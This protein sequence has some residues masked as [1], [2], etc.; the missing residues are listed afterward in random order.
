VCTGALQSIP[1]DVNEAATVDGASPWQTFRL[2][3]L[4]LLLVSVAPLLIASFAF[5]FNNF[6]VI[7]MLTNGGPRD[8]DAPIPVGFTDILI[9]MVYKVAFT[10]QNRDYGLASA[11]S[12]II[13]LI[14]AIIAVVS[15][16]RTK[17]LEEIQR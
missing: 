1:E 11:F 8:T 9:S 10:G 12:I 3:K 14:V 4:P 6:N 7:Y 5:N 2:I 16:S 17:A 13:F 15:F